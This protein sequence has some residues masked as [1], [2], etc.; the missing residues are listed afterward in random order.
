M[1]E[2]QVYLAP[3]PNKTC[4]RIRVITLMRSSLE[5]NPLRVDITMAA[6]TTVLVDLAFPM[7][8]VVTKATSLLKHLHGVLPDLVALTTLLATMLPTAAA[9]APRTTML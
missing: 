4:H 2:A 9:V 7:L 3:T 1:L 6:L 5:I 8:A